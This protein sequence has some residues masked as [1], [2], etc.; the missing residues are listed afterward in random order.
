MNK[1]LLLSITILCSL[2]LSAQSVSKDSIAIVVNDGP[3]VFIEK[4]HLIE[5]RILNNKVQVTKTDL[6]SYQ[7]EF[8]P[9]ASI[10]KNVDQIVA[11]SDIHGQ[12]DLAIELLINNNII[13]ENL[14]WK[15]GEGHFVIVGDVFDRGPK[16]TE[17]LWFLY[18]LEA[19]AKKA[20]GKVHF[21][22]GNH[23]YMVLHNDLRYIHEKYIETSKLLQLEYS[24]LFGENS[25][26]GKWLRSKA[27]LVKI[28]D[29]IFVHGGIS[30]DFLIEDFNIVMTNDLMRASIDREKVEMKSS[31]FYNRYYGKHGPIWY[32]GYFNDTLNDESIGEILKQID[33]NHL[34]VGHCSQDSVLHLYD[35]KIFAVDSSIKYGTYGEVLWI[36]AESYSRGTLKGKKIKFN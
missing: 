12:F 22:L 15:F 23:E 34:V 6:N 30:P 1:I 29:N 24:E 17:T 27:A 14:N 13:D 18:H 8:D 4:D 19:Q 9:E 7:T 33:A 36:D 26:L 2:A 10:Y 25:V 16:V 21:L 20:G 3:Y 11:L 32:R 35:Q 5:K 28:N 31:G